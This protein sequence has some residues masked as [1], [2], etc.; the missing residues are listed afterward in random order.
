MS[1]EI[2]KSVVEWR[3]NVFQRWWDMLNIPIA[4]IPLI[5]G[6]TQIVLW[7][8]KVIPPLPVWDIGLLV[9][10]TI[11]FILVSFWAFHQMRVQRDKMAIIPLSDTDIKMM[12]WRREY[13]KEQISRITQVPTILKM[14]WV[15]VADTLEKKRDNECSSEKLLNAIADILDIKK[16]SK[17]LR[18][19]QYG[20]EKSIRRAIKLFRARMNLRRPNLKLESCWRARTAKEM[21]RHEIGLMLD[22]N[23]QYKDLI[24]QLEDVSEPISKTKVY[25]KIDSFLDNL[26]ALYSVK[27][28]MFY[29]GTKKELHKFPSEVRD[30]LEQVEKGVEREMRTRFV[31][32]KDILEEYSIGEVL[33]N[34]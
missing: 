9:G 29:G 28:L 12:E 16:D 33:T 26:S 13:R 22:K 19:K 4:A 27:L 15:L 25:Q 34:G 18:P 5:W 24:K 8:R 10:G 30:I 31:Q 6:I 3:A 21:D 11:L 20:D 17:L 2:W 7:S 23:I 32:V 1:N 14:I